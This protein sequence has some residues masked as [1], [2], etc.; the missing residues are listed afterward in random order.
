MTKEIKKKLEEADMILVGIGEEF[1]ETDFLDANAEYRQISMAAAKAGAQWV[2]P[3]VNHLFL[4]DDNHLK[5]A[6]GELAKLLEGKNYFVISTCM[7]GMF[8]ETGVRLDRVVEP[9]GSCFRMQCKKGCPD[10]VESSDERLLKQIAMCCESKNFTQMPDRPVCKSCGE[11]MECN[12]LYAEHYAE[13]GYREQWEA[14]TKWLQGTLNRK[15]CVLELGAGM[16]FA[17]VHRFRFEKI[18]GLN[19]K[20]ELIRV[21]RNLYQLPEE[22]GDRGLGISQNAVEFMAQM[23][24]V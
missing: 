6:Y 10:S 15:L 11:P 4:K 13:E 24:E 17:G 9:C 23:K 21:H 18:V 3:Y 7:D 2:I 22:I 16:M 1:A 5:D 20:A 12:S 19:K 8:S 14:Y